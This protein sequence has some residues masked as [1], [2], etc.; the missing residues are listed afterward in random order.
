MRCLNGSRFESL[1][2]S[3]VV[4]LIY[5][6]KHLSAVLMSNGCTCVAKLILRN[7]VRNIIRC[8]SGQFEVFRDFPGAPLALG[9]LLWAT[10]LLRRFQFDGFLVKRGLGKFEKENF[11]QE[12]YFQLCSKAQQQLSGVG[13]RIAPILIHGTRRLRRPNN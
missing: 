7:K 13:D 2:N 5:I 12:L 1:I 6:D 9:T 8:F 4:N 11:H 3:G 10:F